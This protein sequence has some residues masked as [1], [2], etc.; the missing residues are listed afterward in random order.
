MA[1][2][3]PIVEKQIVKA[4]HWRDRGGSPEEAA[5]I[6]E[7]FVEAVEDTIDFANPVLLMRTDD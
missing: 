6:L 7:G 1:E 2:I 3:P 5:R 4:L